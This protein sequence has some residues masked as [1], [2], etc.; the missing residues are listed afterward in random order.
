MDFGT[1]SLISGGIAV[2]LG[3]V[4]V[5]VLIFARRNRY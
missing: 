3:I 5:G 4:Y 2:F 1:L